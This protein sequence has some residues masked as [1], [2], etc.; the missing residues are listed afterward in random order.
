MFGALF[1]YLRLS[2]DNLVGSKVTIPAIH[3][4]EKTSTFL[5]T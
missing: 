4:V 2:D 3:I 1:C 5:F